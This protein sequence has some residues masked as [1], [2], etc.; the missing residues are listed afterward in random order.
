MAA[1]GSRYSRPISRIA[2]DGQNA[3][4]PAIS[5]RACLPPYPKGELGSLRPF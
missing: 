4:A 5:P 1:G 2:T 3:S